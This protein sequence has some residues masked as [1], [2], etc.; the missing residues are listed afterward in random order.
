MAERMGLLECRFRLRPTSRGLDYVQVGASLSVGPMRLSLPRFLGPRVTATTWA[1]ERGMGLDV[2]VFAPIFGR[3]L[4]Y[5][6]VV[7]PEGEEA[8][9]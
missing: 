1:E 4:R 3:V 8:A 2:S 7:A 5:H 6:G 9:S